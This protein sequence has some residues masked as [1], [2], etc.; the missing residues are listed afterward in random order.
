MVDAL[1][2]ARRIDVQ[3]NTEVLKVRRWTGESRIVQGSRMKCGNWERKP[4]RWSQGSA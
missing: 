1:T 4:R 3:E 2:L